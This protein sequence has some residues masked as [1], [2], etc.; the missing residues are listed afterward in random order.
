MCSWSVL[1]L[2]ARS[3]S[4]WLGTQGLRTG[5]RAEEAN[6]RLI[7]EGEGIH[8]PDADE[9]ISL[10]GLL[11]GRRSGETQALL[12]CWLDSRRERQTGAVI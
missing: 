5:T 1:S 9:D 3:R 7:G 2:A 4:R 10:D 12:R 6:W 8:W 11:A